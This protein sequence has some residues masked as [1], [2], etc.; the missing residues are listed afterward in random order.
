MIKSDFI[1][2]MRAVILLSN[3]YWISYSNKNNSLKVLSVNHSPPMQLGY[4][5]IGKNSW[6]KCRNN[7]LTWRYKIT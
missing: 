4:L 1:F 3:Q 5:K 7:G 6:P 2:E